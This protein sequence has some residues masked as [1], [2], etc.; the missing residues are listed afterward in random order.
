MTGVAFD[1]KEFAVHDG[2]GIRTT[3][4]L[5]GCPLRCTWCHNPEGQSFKPECMVSRASCTD[6]G[7]CR[8]VCGKEACDACGACLPH[9]PLGLRRIVGAAWTADQLA[10]RLLRDCALMEESGGGVTFSGGEPMSQWPFVREVMERLSGVHCAIETSG[11]C[12]KAEFLGAMACADLIMLDL[13]LTDPA[14]HKKY[15]GVDNA[16]ILDN[17]RLLRDGDT[18][19]VVR[20]PVIPG[21]NDDGAHFAAVA[22]LLRGAHALVSVELMP[23]HVTAGAKYAMI[24]RE[25]APGFDVAR[26]VRADLRPFAERGVPARVL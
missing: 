9:C 18:P 3:V 21:V 8:S 15:I 24:G 10:A 16:P 6:C 17:A 22:E 23:Y 26:P 2:P 5:K 25:Y 11:Y 19:F 13:K 12:A 14:L 20:I 7:A 4:F 1:V